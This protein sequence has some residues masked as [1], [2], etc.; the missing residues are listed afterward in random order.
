MSFQFAERMETLLGSYFQSCESPKSVRHAITLA[1]LIHCFNLS[2]ITMDCLLSSSK[3][4]DVSGTQPSDSQEGEAV[5]LKDELS[6][7]ELIHLGEFIFKVITVCI[8]SVSSVFN[9]C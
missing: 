4:S 9:V 5:L 7:T 1:D 2:D 8:V 6:N 3:Q